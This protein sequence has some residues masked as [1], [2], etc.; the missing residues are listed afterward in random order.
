VVKYLYIAS[1]R[2]IFID[3]KI[4]AVTPEAVRSA[5]IIDIAG[6]IQILTIESD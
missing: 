4:Y 5:E 2:R 6:T 3:D 1:Y